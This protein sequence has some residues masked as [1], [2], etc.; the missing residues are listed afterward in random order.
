MTRNFQGAENTRVDKIWS[1]KSSCS[2]EGTIYSGK[3]GDAFGIDRHD[4]S[5][6]KLEHI[7]CTDYV[8]L[9]PRLS[10]QTSRSLTLLFGLPHPEFSRGSGGM[11]KWQPQGLLFQ[12]W[13]QAGDFLAIEL[14][15][16]GASCVVAPRNPL[17]ALTFLSLTRLGS[18][19]GWGQIF[20]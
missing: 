4:R 18:I 20:S 3:S 1:W 9:I 17:P 12:S 16:G 15:G 6:R 19:W 14:V 11:Q 10:A 5:G 13:P 8:V 7:M 2:Q